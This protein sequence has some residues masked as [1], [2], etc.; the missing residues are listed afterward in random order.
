[1]FWLRVATSRGVQASTFGK[2][3]RGGAAEDLKGHRVTANW[4]ES[5]RQTIA[6]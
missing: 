4:Q 5:S 2:S 1:M 3:V 6:K